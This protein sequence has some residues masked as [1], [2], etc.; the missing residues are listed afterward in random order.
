M[1]ITILYIVKKHHNVKSTQ[2]KQ[3]EKYIIFWSSKRE[4]NIQWALNVY[5]PHSKTTGY[6]GDTTYL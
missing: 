6:H 3:E 2:F 4:S 5:V 1:Q